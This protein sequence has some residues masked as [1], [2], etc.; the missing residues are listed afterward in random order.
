MIPARLLP[1][2][3]TDESHIRITS[4]VSVK[5][6]GVVA[7]SLYLPGLKKK[8]IYHPGAQEGNQTQR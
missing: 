5:S 3:R 8:D 1:M 7:G 2:L 4:L 6:I